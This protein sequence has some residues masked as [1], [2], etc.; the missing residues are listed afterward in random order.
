MGRPKAELQFGSTTLL[1]RM[2]AELRHTFPEIVLVTSPAGLAGARRLGD[3]R[4][5]PDER[6]YAGPLRALA[7]GLTAIR[8]DGAFVCACDSPLLR[9]DLASLLCA[10]L[11]RYDAVV[12]E[13]A[14]LAQPLHAAYRKRCV[15]A[16][17]S[18]IAR[19]EERLVQI[20]EAVSARKVVEEELRAVDPD[21]LS[22]TN[23]NTPEDYERALRLVFSAG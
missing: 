5:V 7:L 14:G 2:V 12:P 19:G 8:N 23:V 16:I 18:M 15:A 21:L 11:E 6:E 4:I 3:V 10:M 9:A 1:E 17:N 13:I 22:F 20:V